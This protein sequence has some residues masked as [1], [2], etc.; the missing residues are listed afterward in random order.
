MRRPL[1]HRVPQANNVAASSAVRFFREHRTVVG[2]RYANGR[3]RK[4]YRSLESVSRLTAAAKTKGTA[5][6]SHGGHDHRCNRE[7]A[8]RR[9]ASDRLDRRRRQLSGQ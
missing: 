9:G 5:Q 7:A 3:Q 1:Y 8:T 2:D 4:P 6:D